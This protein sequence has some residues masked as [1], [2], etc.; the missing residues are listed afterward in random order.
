MRVSRMTVSAAGV[1]V[2][3]LVGAQSAAAFDCIRVSSSVTGMNASEHSGHWFTIDVSTREAVQQTFTVLG[4]PVPTDEQA[5]CFVASYAATG[6]PDHF[7]IGQGVGGPRGVLAWRNTTTVGDG[8]GIDHLEASSI[9][10]S[11]LAAIEA[12]DIPVT[13]G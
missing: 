7:A 13:D 5:D 6:D 10:G 2:A 1:A 3:A 9:V 11:Y 12:C 8:R 4:D